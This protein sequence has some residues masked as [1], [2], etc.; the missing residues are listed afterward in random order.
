MYKRQELRN[1]PVGGASR[2]P[3]SLLGLFSRRLRL[4]PGVVYLSP[5][6]KVIDLSEVRWSCACFS[7]PSIPRRPST[8]FSS[9]LA[10][11]RRALTPSLLIPDWASA[12]VEAPRN[13]S[14]STVSSILAPPRKLFSN[15]ESLID[16][17]PR[18]SS[19]ANPSLRSLASGFPRKSSFVKSS[20]LAG[21]L[22]ELKSRTLY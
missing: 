19:F 12:R 2:S 7:L 20:N 6:L 14:S 15:P 9:V 1:A 16:I 8:L 3:I 10:L 5:I 13:F 11:K 4:P 18:K 17:P 22:V 21:L